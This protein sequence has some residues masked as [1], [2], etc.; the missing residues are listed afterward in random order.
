VVSVMR[1]PRCSGS[2]LGERITAKS[3]LQSGE[4]SAHCGAMDPLLDS[5]EY[6]TSMSDGA[7]VLGRR[8][9]VAAAAALC[10]TL[11]IGILGVRAAGGAAQSRTAVTV[12]VTVSPPT[13]VYGV[14][15]QVFSVTIA[16]PASGD[17]SPTGV[18]TVS[19]LQ[20]NLCPPISLPSPGLGAVTVICADSTVP[21]PVNSSTIADYSYSGDQN[22]LVAKGKVSGAVTA[23]DTTTS[24]IASSATGTWGDEQSLV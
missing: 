24:V 10:L 15:D 23:A 4:V 12:T 13:E 21:I 5:C 3:S 19:D 11:A 2:G 17:V 9:A 14:L 8:V 6:A 7:V 20:V 18:V 16:P 1:R 22:Y